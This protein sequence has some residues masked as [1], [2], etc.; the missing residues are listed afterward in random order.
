MNAH[1]YSDDD[2][3]LS[4]ARVAETSSFVTPGSLAAR[5]LACLLA[6]DRDAA[7][8]L[9]DDVRR[10]GVSVRELYLDVIQPTQYEVGRLWE[11]DRLSVAEE[12]YCTGVSQLVIARLYPS[13]LK[14]P[15]PNAPRALVACV[16][17]E[18]HELGARMVADF[19][20][21]DGWDTLYIGATCPARAAAALVHGRRTELFAISCALTAHLDAARELVQAV[22]E[23]PLEAPPRI[24]VGGYAYRYDAE[25][26][27]SV[28]A[29]GYALDADGAVRMARALNS[30]GVSC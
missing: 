5:Y 4:A 15:A 7:T 8:A 3:T 16:D 14:V 22:R 29:D 28:G 26:W 18:L 20:E 21:M 25:I 1:G 13:W 10:D 6:A 30:P 9:I 2:G 27:R 24:L 11:L 19:L 12:H 17:C 23:L